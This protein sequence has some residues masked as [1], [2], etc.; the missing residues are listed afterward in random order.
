MLY[1]TPGIVFSKSKYGDNCLIARIYTK[2]F[3]LQSYL[4][5]GARRKKTAVKASIIQPLALLDMVVYYKEARGLQRI[6]ELKS[7]HPFVSIPFDFKKNSIAL[8]LA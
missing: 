8:F 6:K 7:N 2:T 1:K 3:G 4:V 5:Q